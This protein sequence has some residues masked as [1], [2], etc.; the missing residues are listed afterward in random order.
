MERLN[1]NPHIDGILVQLPLPLSIETKEIVQSIEP[2]KDIDLSSQNQNG[3]DSDYEFSDM[4]IAE[5]SQSNWSFPNFPSHLDHI[6]LYNNPYSTSTQT[7]RL[8]DYIIGG[9]GKYNNYISDH[10]PV[11]VSILFDN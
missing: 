1:N 5:G 3:I 2:S 11:G 7:L 6:L 8:D 4:Y 9:W 10:R